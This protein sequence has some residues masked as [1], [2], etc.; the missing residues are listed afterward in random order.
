[1]SENCILL[2]IIYSECFDFYSMMIALNLGDYHITQNGDQ[3]V[4]MKN[5]STASG[6]SCLS[7]FNVIA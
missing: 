5:L 6:Y 3:Q 7:L 2:V 1:M 4:D